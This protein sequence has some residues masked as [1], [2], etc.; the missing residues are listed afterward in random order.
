MIYI[1]FVSAGPNGTGG[2]VGANG[3]NIDTGNNNVIISP[4]AMVNSTDGIDDI[5]VILRI[6]DGKSFYATFGT[7]NSTLGKLEDVVWISHLS[8][9]IHT[10]HCKTMDYITLLNQMSDQHCV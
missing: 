2:P 4:K 7:E 1:A 3:D 9:S 6:R 8:N 5:G 10:I